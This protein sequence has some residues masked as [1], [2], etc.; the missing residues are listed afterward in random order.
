MKTSL[1]TL[2][3]TCLL[4]ISCTDKD[5]GPG[6]H[7]IQE[8]NEY[9]GQAKICANDPEQTKPNEISQEQIKLIEECQEI[10]VQDYNFSK[11]ELQCARSEQGRCYCNGIEARNEPSE[12]RTNYPHS[13]KID[14]NFNP[15][16][17]KQVTFEIKT[18]P[19]EPEKVIFK[20]GNGGLPEE[21]CPAG[22]H[23]EKAPWQFKGTN[24]GYINGYIYSCEPNPQ[25]EKHGSCLNCQPDIQIILQHSNGHEYPVTMREL[26]TP[27]NTS[28]V[29]PSQVTLTPRDSTNDDE[30]DSL[31]PTFECYDKEGKLVPCTPDCQDTIPP[32]EIR[33]S[34]EPQ[35]EEPK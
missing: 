18:Q 9:T 17:R 3:L 13:T 35:P 21:N 22:T 14:L 31:T 28:Q 10:A 4:L 30:K 6:F 20:V 27:P 19:E 29:T 1:L 7:L 11:E 8:G 15:P 32:R 24:N 12:I 16:Y 34:N 33:T 2:T 23:P 26:C 5:C 25:P